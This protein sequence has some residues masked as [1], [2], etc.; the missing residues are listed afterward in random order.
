LVGW[1]AGPRAA[2]MPRAA[3][4][5]GFVLLL[6]STALYVVLIGWWYMALDS[7]SLVDM[8]MCV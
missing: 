4:D 5:T 8:Y 7:G 1:L 3:D 6:L 2:A